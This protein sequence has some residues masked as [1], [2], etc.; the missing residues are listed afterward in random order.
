MS[1]F[2]QSI[3]TALPAHCL[4]QE[5]ISTRQSEMLALDER[6]AGW[7]RKV[8]ARTGIDQR[9]TVLLDYIEKEQLWVDAPPTMGTRNRIYHEAAPKL[10]L[11][12]AKNAL[13]GI[14]PSTITH[15]IS[16]SCTGV[17]APGIEVHLIDGLGLALDTQRYGI[18]MMGCFGAFRGLA[19]ASALALQDPRHRILVVCTELCTLHMQD[20]PN[21]DT[22]LANALFADGAAAVVVGGETGLWEIIRNRSLLLDNRDAMRWD[23]GDDAFVM[24]LSLEVPI[25]IR[26][27]IASFSKQ[28]LQQIPLADCDWAVHPGGSA[29]LK[30]IEEACSLQKHQTEASWA[31]L[32]EMGNMSSPTFLFVLERLISSSTPWTVGL[33]FGPGL[34]VEGILLRK[35]T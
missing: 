34:S 9:Y 7:F 20:S 23:A 8:S 13:Q 31:I 21:L 5:E 14:D 3:G 29:I 27:A 22:L 28:L 10:A 15:V 30:G 17:I 2:I 24:R 16:V 12:A 19:M 18:N 33:G 32:R 1:G 4:A 26:G 11:Q 25:A 35:S 6:R